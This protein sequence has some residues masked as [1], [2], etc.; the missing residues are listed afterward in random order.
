MAKAATYPQPTLHFRVDPRR[1]KWTEHVT[2][3]CAYCG[4]PIAEETVP[5]HLSRQDGT[6][7]QFCDLCAEICFGLIG[8]DDEGQ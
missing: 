7:A 6:S 2:D 5:L 1:V 8:V 4:A 3:S